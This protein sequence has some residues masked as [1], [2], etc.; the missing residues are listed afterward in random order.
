MRIAAA[1]DNEAEKV[2]M[3]IIDPPQVP[4]IP[5]APRRP[6]LLSGVL[7]AGL[8]AGLGLALLLQQFDRSFHSIEDLRE[9]G[10][11]VVGGISLMGVTV[12]MRERVIS[13]ATFATAV[14][15]LCAVYSG[16]LYRLLHTPG[17]A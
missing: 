10:L 8:A 6:L 4:Q 14:L 3:Q 2:K 12:R 17:V 7:V 9:L 5:A 13:V 16:L 11:P 15:L 1:A